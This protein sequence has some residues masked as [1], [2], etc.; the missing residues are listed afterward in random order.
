MA[1]VEYY[2]PQQ[3][4][5]YRTAS[6]KL[7]FRFFYEDTTAQTINTNLHVLKISPIRIEFEAKANE[8]TIRLPNFTLTL[9]GGDFFEGTNFTNGKN[10]T[11]IEIY[12]DGQLY[13]TGYLDFNSIQ[14]SDYYVD[15]G[16]LKYRTI[17]FKIFDGIKYYYD[18]NITLSDIG[19]TGSESLQS[20]VQTM[21]SKFHNGSYYF[22][23]QNIIS[24]NCGLNYTFNDLKLAETSGN[25]LCRTLLSYI[26]R[27][28]AL[29]IFNL[30]GIYYVLPRQGESA[31]QALSAESLLSVKKLENRA[32]IKYI[33]I[34]A[35]KNWSV[36]TSN[37]IGN[38]EHK[39]T[40]G[41]SYVQDFKKI[42]ID[43]T[44]FFKRLTVQYKGASL[45][46]YPT[47][48]VYP[49]DYSTDWAMKYGQ[50][51]YSNEI[52]TGMIFAAEYSLSS[53]INDL[54]KSQEDPL[55]PSTIY[56]KYYFADMN[57]DGRVFLIDKTPSGANDR[58]LYKIQKCVEYLASVFNSLY[59]EKENNLTFKIHGIT[60]IDITKKVN[61]LSFNRPIRKLIIDLLNNKTH[62]TLF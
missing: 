62:C 37:T 6:G 16:A 50:D 61:I 17:K 25:F 3:G 56:S 24:E 28:L 35:T 60:S 33:E 52:E 51:A 7:K 39:K 36:L 21:L 10:K 13:F 5:E 45:S 31:S 58:T 19:Y 26:I 38:Y 29:N 59:Y 49:D 15:N 11:F 14:K 44:D 27:Y 8:Q 54:I 30:N 48:A 1:L 34:K 47:S 55:D 41:V 40:V 22:T 2:F 42:I 20:L 4:Y 57:Y 32:V 18:N 9:Q 12:R 53:P 23:A 43:A 46:D